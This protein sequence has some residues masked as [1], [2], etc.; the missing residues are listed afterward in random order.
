MP[1]EGQLVMKEGAWK[2]GGT[3]QTVLVDK[4]GEVVATRDT[5]KEKESYGTSR[6][7]YY[8]NMHMMILNS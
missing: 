8:K 4:E 6:Y 1:S 3:T 2:M 7:L 5:T